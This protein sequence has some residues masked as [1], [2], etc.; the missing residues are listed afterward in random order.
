M[1]HIV[2]VGI[3][4][5]EVDRIRRMLEDHP[6]QF[7]DRC[8]TEGEDAYCAPRVNAAESFAARF[9]VK[10]A[11]MKV[12]GTGWAEGVAWRH[13]EVVKD[14]AGAVSVNLTGGAAERAAALGIGMVHVSITHTTGMAAAVAVAERD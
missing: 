1:S 9:A 13:I 14:E 3:D 4:L 5:V 7:R 8:F 6:A 12:L 2:G 10:E 11:V